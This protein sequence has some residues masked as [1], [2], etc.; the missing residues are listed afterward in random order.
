MK[1]INKM[2]MKKLIIPLVLLTLTLLIIGCQNKTMEHYN[3]GKIKSIYSLQNNKIEGLVTDYFENGE[4]S[5]KAYYRDGLPDGP[6]FMYYPSGS[7]KILST[8]VNG[9]P[10]GT[11]I[12][13]FETGELKEILN[14]K[15]GIAFGQVKNFYRN[16]TLKGEIEIY[17]DS[18]T[19]SV[20]YDESGI[21]S[22]IYR[23]AII[24]GPDTITGEDP[25][26]FTVTLCGPIDKSLKCYFLA[27]PKGTEYQAISKNIQ[28]NPEGKAN[29]I[30]DKEELDI[31]GVS[32]IVIERLKG[33]ETIYHR[34]GK[35]IL[36]K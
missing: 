31:D 14:I 27:N 13:Y 12:S 5:R 30:L 8:N 24:E 36:K 18:I 9:L 23:I 11:S 4:I 25:V 20:R 6:E 21:A 7:L 28:L 29:I 22:S 15:N 19:Y 34:A 3:N 2:K 26:K 1:E 10:T 33:D 32:F 35:P 17:G 16:G